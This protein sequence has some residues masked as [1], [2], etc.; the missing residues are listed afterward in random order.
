MG[1]S[2]PHKASHQAYAI[3]DTKHERAKPAPLIEIIS[4]TAWR[5]QPL[6]PGRH[7][8]SSH[9]DRKLEPQ[10]S[11]SPVGLGGLNGQ[12]WVC[13]NRDQ[14]AYDGQGQ[15]PG[16]PA[17][18]VGP[19]GASASVRARCYSI[20]PASTRTSMLGDPTCQHSPGTNINASASFH[21]GEDQNPPS[22][23]TAACEPVCPCRHM[24][25]NRPHT[26]ELLCPLDF[27]RICRMACS[28]VWSMSS[29]ADGC[30]SALPSPPSAPPTFSAA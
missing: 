18:H 23:L 22:N 26:H 13:Q 27:M 4:S 30:A 24:Q 7:A 6:R 8:C 21:A 19:I 17:S 11:R 15:E 25:R 10:S 12:E 28:M 5:Q 16:Q 20:L 3:S 29:L 14:H 2:K 9:T 1:T